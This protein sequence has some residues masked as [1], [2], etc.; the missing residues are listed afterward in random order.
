[1]DT[2]SLLFRARQCQSDGRLDEAMFFFNKILRKDPKQTQAIIGAAEIAKC[3]GK[4]QT[5]YQLLCQVIKLAPHHAEAF[6]HRGNLLQILGRSKDAINDFSIAMNL[7]RQTASIFNS[8]G[9]AF[10]HLG[11]FDQAIADF[12]EAIDRQCNLAD[13]FYNR[14]LAHR[15][16][17]NY[18]SAIDDYTTTINLKPDHF[19]AYNNRGFAHR[20]LRQYSDAIIDFE[21]CVEINPS[22]HDAYWNASLCLLAL[23]NFQKGWA[24]YEYRWSSTSFTSPRRNFSA[25]LWLGKEHLAGKT[26]LIHSEQGLGDTL[27]FCRYVPMIEALDCKVILEVEQPLIGIMR[28]LSRKIKLIHKNSELP[29]FDYHCPLMSLPLA[30]STTLKTIPN[31]LPYLEVDSSRVAYWKGKLGVKNKPRIGLVWR[32]NPAHQKDSERSIPLR[33]ILP[34]LSPDFDWISLQKDIFDDEKKMI[35]A[36]KKIINYGDEISDFADSGALCKSLDAILCVDTSIAHL[37]GAL[38]VPTH[39]LLPYISDF[40]WHTDGV[41]SRW[42][43]TLRLYRQGR[44]RTWDESLKN[45]QT[46][47]KRGF[48][49]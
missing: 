7:N 22:F 40:R 34:W 21:K 48:L 35:E 43:K 30:F 5:A 20:E 15:K 26:I 14:A 49:A 17:G 19:Q 33:D 32:G 31:H 39:L 47:I 11:N 46:A 3:L 6:E 9:I 25:P 42:Y 2:Q 16:K 44:D 8:R 10:A 27:Q 24:L 1:M 12:S 18:A 28:S 38:C 37:A 29:K 4:H 13:T 45:A 23:G 36:S 41:A